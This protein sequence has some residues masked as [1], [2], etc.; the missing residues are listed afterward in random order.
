MRL[1]IVASELDHRKKPAL[2]VAMSSELVQLSRSGVMKMLVYRLIS[3][4]ILSEMSVHRRVIGQ[5]A[6]DAA[7]LRRSSMTQRK[8]ALNVAMS[9]EYKQFSILVLLKNISF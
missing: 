1:G 3:A 9:S 7:L 4:I 8:L 5:I 2:T 6:C